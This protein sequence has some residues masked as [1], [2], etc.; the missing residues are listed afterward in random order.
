MSIVI[1]QVHGFFARI[2]LM[3]HDDRAPRIGP[4]AQLAQKEIDVCH[5]Q[6]RSNFMVYPN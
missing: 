6:F 1:G 3:C 5:V 2:L 4:A